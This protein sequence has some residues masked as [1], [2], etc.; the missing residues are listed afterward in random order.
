[1]EIEEVL[2]K[3]FF[4][5]LAVYLYK[6]VLPKNTDTDQPISLMGSPA[7]PAM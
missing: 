5:S 6:I 2:K 3:G 7:L 4:D 1:M